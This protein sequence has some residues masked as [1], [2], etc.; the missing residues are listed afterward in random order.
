MKFKNFFGSS[1]SSPCFRTKHS[2]TFNGIYIYNNIDPNLHFTN[3]EVEVK[4]TGDILSHEKQKKN[5]VSHLER[6]QVP[7]VPSTS[8]DGNTIFIPI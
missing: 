6:Y 8:I 7:I 1:E 4:G 2:C 5:C 3:I